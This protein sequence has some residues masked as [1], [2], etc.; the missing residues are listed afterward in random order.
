MSSWW[1]IGFYSGLLFM[2]TAGW[3][4]TWGKLLRE[5][6]ETEYYRS[7]AESNLRVFR[8]ADANTPGNEIMATSFENLC[9]AI[10]YGGSPEEFELFGGSMLTGYG[11]IR[12]EVQPA[13]RR[14]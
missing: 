12:L 7:I 9:M 6:K 4:V 11:T 10:K 13:E 8:S 5:R 1:W 14:K 3:S 2:T